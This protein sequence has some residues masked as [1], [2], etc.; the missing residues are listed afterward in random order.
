MPDVSFGVHYEVGVA[1][2]I[3]IPIVLLCKDKQ[4]LTF[5]MQGME[6]LPHT[7]IITYQYLY[8]LDVK[9]RDKLQ[10]IFPG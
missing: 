7:A 8:D 4:Q 6:S 3:G 10:H 9:L 5:L 1:A 2:G